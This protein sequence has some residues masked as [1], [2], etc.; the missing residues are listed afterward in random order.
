MNV[1]M[2]L[3][4]PIIV[5]VDGTYLTEGTPEKVQHDE[6]VVDAYLGR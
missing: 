1:I 5:M 2:K 3:C 6:K 4:N